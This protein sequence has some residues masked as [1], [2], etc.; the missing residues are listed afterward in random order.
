[1]ESKGL[2][3]CVCVCEREGERERERA[4]IHS[5]VQYRIAICYCA[6]FAYH[7]NVLKNPTFSFNSILSRKVGSSGLKVTGKRRIK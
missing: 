4:R 3:V 7:G 1:M 2:C 6:E 5:V